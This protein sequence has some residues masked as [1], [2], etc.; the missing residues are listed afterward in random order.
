M[1][2]CRAWG[3]FLGF[4]GG[5]PGIWGRDYEGTWDLSWFL[6]FRA[7]FCQCQKGVLGVWAHPVSGLVF[8]DLGEGAE[9]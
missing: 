7:G 6:W 2:Q 8:Q 9:V 4:G 5:P 1:V 3:G